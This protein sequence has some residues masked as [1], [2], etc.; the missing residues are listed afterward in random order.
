MIKTHPIFD[1][2]TFDQKKTKEEEED[3]VSII[4]NEHFKKA[5]LF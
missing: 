1:T 2:D 3:L 5:D 4:K